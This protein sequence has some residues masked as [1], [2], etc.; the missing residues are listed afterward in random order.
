LLKS[1]T[2]YFPSAGALRLSRAV[3]RAPQD[4][5]AQFFAIADPITDKEDERYTA[6]STISEIDSIMPDKAE[7]K[8]DAPVRGPSF[9]SMHLRDYFFERIP[10][11][12]VEVNNIARLFPSERAITIV[13]TGMEARKREMPQTHLG[14][15]RFLHFA[16]HGFLPVEPGI[17]EPALVLSYDGKDEDRM[18]LSLSEILSL[19][20]HAEM[21]VLSACNTGSGKVTRAEGVASLGMAFLSAGAESA[22]VSLWQVP[23]KSTSLLMQEFYK[24]LLHGM[25]K[26]QALASARESL[27]RQGYSNP[28]FWAPFVLTGE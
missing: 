5:P 27:V 24:N 9:E 23:D 12:E 28:F 3:R 21:V 7:A 2:T 10:E 20:L 25:S 18:M 14:K 1:A 11:T 4:W 15:F 8:T 17:R 19:K 26:S 13:R 22:T 16:T 6:A